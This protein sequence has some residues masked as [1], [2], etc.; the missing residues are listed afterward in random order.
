MFLQQTA[1]ESETLLVA[2]I[3]ILISISLIALGVLAYTLLRM[4][5][6]HP[7]KQRKS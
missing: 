6:K 5:A 7:P 4:A 2:L 1:K 3:A